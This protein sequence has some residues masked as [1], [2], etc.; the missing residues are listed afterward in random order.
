MLSHVF[1]FGNPLMEEDSLPLR[2][3]PGLKDAFPSMDFVELD[4]TEDLR[5]LGRDPVIIDTALGIKEVKVL[6][7]IEAIEPSPSCSMHD[8]DLGTSLKLLRRMG[9]LDSVTIIAVPPRM[10]LKRAMNGV[11]DALAKL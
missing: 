2:L 10:E 4:P 5:A 6:T 9:L 7:D 11:R 3:L 1:V 8:L